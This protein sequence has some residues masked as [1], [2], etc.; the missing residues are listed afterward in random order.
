MQS[1][2]SLI[3]LSALAGAP[4]E[5]DPQCPCRV[6]DP[7]SAGGETDNCGCCCHQRTRPVDPCRPEPPPRG[8]AP[9]PLPAPFYEDDPRGQRR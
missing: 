4:G 6:L 8:R 2:A 5:G 9:V 1:I 3:L 7:P